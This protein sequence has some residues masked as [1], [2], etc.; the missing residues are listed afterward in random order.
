MRDPQQSV[1]AP[2]GRYQPA[3]PASRASG[4]VQAVLDNLLRV[5]DVVLNLLSGVWNLVLH[6][7]LPA[8]LAWGV[9]AARGLD[10]LSP[11]IDEG[12]QRRLGPLAL[13]LSIGAAII[14]TESITR[15]DRP[16]GIG[17]YLLTTV[18]VGAAMF[19]FL[20]VGHHVPMHLT[21]DQIAMALSYAYLALRVGMGVLI[22]A[23][24]S[25]VLLSHPAL[26]D[27]FHRR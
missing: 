21:P 17:K 11:L 15:L 6:V 2:P 27:I 23:L 18:A 5:L 20:A 12:L 16:F 7:G 26:V 25:W 4:P 24:V 3:S 22:G 10:V 13:L 9:G 8:V 14:T 1:F 19:P